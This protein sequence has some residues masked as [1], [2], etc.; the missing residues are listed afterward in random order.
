MSSLEILASI[1][2]LGVLAAVIHILVAKPV[3]GSATLAAA[4]SLGFGAY[5]L[6]TIAREGVALVWENHTT[7]LWG[8]RSGGTCSLQSASRFSLPR[9]ELARSG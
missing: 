6:L 4:L 2:L 9:R 7:N 5:S 8:C 1:G 3:I